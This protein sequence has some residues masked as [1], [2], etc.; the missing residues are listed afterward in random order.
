MLSTILEHAVPD[1]ALQNVGD[2]RANIV[3]SNKTTF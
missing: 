3:N 1:K 2:K